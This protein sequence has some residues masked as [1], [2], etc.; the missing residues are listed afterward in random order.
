MGSLPFGFE[1][2]ILVHLV[3][4]LLLE[5]LVLG[6][7]LLGQLD[8]HILEVALVPIRNNVNWQGQI[9]QSLNHDA[10]GKDHIA[11]D[12]DH[13]ALVLLQHRLVLLFFLSLCNDLLHHVLVVLFAAQGLPKLVNKECNVLWVEQGAALRVIL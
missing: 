3:H 8:A 11:F 9:V 10:D 5:E 2:D 7:G 4:L 6:K 13:V 12:L 1:H